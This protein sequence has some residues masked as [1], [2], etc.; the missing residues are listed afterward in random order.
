MIVWVLLFPVFPLLHELQ[1]SSKDRRSIFLPTALACLC[2]AAGIGSYFVDFEGS[3]ICWP[4]GGLPVFLTYFFNWIGAGL[5]SIGSSKATFAFGVCLLVAAAAC[6]AVATAEAVKDRSLVRLERTWPWLMLL[7]YVFVS[8]VVNTLTRAQLLGMSNALVGR[9]YLITMQM[10]VGLAGL[11]P[12]LICHRA[13]GSPRR[14]QRLRLAIA[15]AV[16]LSGI[17]YTLA[18]WQSGIEKSH[19]Y[20]RALERR[21]MALSLWREAPFISPLPVSQVVPPARLRTQYLAMVQAGLCPD[22]SRGWWLTKALKD[23]RSRDPVGKV[24]LT[25]TGEKLNASGWAMHPVARTPF[26]AVLAVLEQ[27][28]SELTP[29]WVDLMTRKG[30]PLPN[31]LDGDESPFLMGFST[32]PLQGPYASAPAERLL[33]FAIDPENREAYPIRRVR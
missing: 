19:G 11:L 7:V 16:L 21:K 20:Y 2:A 8:G 9:Y 22:N 17:F 6:V 27:Q 14:N 13:D 24:K 15:S 28:N 23:A 1:D 25:G 31:R 4:D 3:P 32:Y 10:T 29:I 33:F 18:G 5:A 26:P 12:I 30:P